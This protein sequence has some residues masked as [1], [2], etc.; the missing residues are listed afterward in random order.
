MPFFLKMQ[1]PG[2]FNG[3]NTVYEVTVRLAG[4]K[5]MVSLSG[6]LYSGSLSSGIGF[7]TR[8]GWEAFQS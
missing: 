2:A 8:C 7:E 5:I 1:S 6:T 4:N 3:I